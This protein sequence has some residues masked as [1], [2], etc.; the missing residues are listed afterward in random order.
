VTARPMVLPSWMEWNTPRSRSARAITRT[1]CTTVATRNRMIDVVGRG[2]ADQAKLTPSRALGLMSDLRA[3][4]GVR[5]EAA[6]EGRRSLKA[7]TPAPAGFGSS[8]PS[9]EL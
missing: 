5:R 9:K 2:V 1:I 7:S 8:R 6:A 3:G 4:C